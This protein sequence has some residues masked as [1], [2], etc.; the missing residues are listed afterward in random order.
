MIEQRRV[1]YL[2]PQ[3]AAAHVQRELEGYEV[4]WAVDDAEV[5]R[6]LPGCDAVLDAYM[7]IRFPAERLAAA[8][9]LRLF[10]TATT[11]AD[12]V[13][14]DA[15]ERRGIPLL[16]LRGQREVLRNITPAAEH[17]WL[18]LMA[19]AR[20]LRAAVDEA[21]TGGW[22]RNNHPGIML[23]G[24]T[25]GLVGCGRIGEWMSRYATA[26]GM[27]V[28]GFDPHL[29]QFPAT[30]EAAPLDRV[31]READFVSVH[32]PLLPETRLLLGEAEI[33]SM[34]PGVVVVN[35][36][37]GEIIDEAALLRALERGHVHAAGLDVLT[38][39]PETAHHPL[40]EYA[41]THPNLVITPHIG[42]F[43]PDALAFVLSFTC[44]R[45][46]DFFAGAGA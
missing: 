4:A 14:A 22:D 3:D 45:I 24:R 25:L 20:G 32:V 6:L 1:L 46:R 26:F 19:C 10:T 12:H 8:E 11:G 29:E 28:I 17:S 21:S 33:A 41:R 38:G 34:K 15:L 9:R 35:T 18:L 31:L 36:S 16:T 2:G 23:R 42:G 40:V 44:G 37:R 27:R 39:E 30:I 43:S 5:E 7:R 13:D